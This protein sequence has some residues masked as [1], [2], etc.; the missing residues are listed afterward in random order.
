MAIS[1]DALGTSVLLNGGVALGVFFIFNFLRRQPFLADF[2]SAKRKLSIPFRF[3]PPRLPPTWFSWMEPV[4][5]MADEKF[6]VCAGFDA[7]AYCRFLKLAIRLS[8]LVSVVSCLITL[9]TNWAAGTFVEKQLKRQDQINEF[10][11]EKAMRE[12]LTEIPTVETECNTPEEPEDAVSNAAA[13]GIGRN[14][15]C[16]EVGFVVADFDK[17]SMTNIDENQSHLLWAHLISLY[18]ITFFTIRMLW[19]YW[20]ESLKWRILYLAWKRKG[21]S[22]HT[23]LVQDIAG[24]PHGT[25][26]GRIYDNIDGTIGRVLPQKFKEKVQQ[27]MQQGIGSVF[28]KVTGKVSG[29]MKDSVGSK[30]SLSGR[31]DIFE[32]RN[33]YVYRR[34]G[35]AAQ[36][37]K[38]LEDI[39]VNEFADPLGT[40]SF[41]SAESPR[42]TRSFGNSSFA[43]A[44]QY[45]TP[46]ANSV[47]AASSMS[48]VLPGADYMLDDSQGPL[49]AYPPEETLQRPTITGRRNLRNFRFHKAR[50]DFQTWEQAEAALQ[51]GV[52]VEELVRREF[53]RTYGEDQVQKVTVVKNELKLGGLYGAYATKKQAVEELTDKWISAL[54]RKATIKRKKVK[55]KPNKKDKARCDKWGVDKTTADEMEYKLWDMQDA[56]DKVRAEQRRVQHEETS[57][58]F[59]QLRSRQDQT[60]LA[61]GLLSYREDLWKASAAPDPAEIIWGSVSWRGWERSLRSMLVWGIFMGMLILM[62]PIIALIQ[63]IV[64]LEG[65]A[66]QDGTVGDI[67]QGI[68]DLP[69]VAQVLPGILPTLGLKIFLALVPIVLRLSALFIEGLPSFSAV[70][71]AVAK[72]FYIFQFI[73]VFVFVS[74]LG[75][76]SSGSSSGSGNAPVLT[77]AKDLADNP[78]QIADWI[79]TAVPQ[80]ASFYL[81]YILTNGLLAKGV[82]FLKIPGAA[83]FFLLSKLAGTK[84]Q[85]KK[86]WANQ[87]MQYGPE[88]ADHTITVLLL[89]LFGVQQPF[90][91][92]VSLAYFICNYFYAPDRK[93]VV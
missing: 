15:I 46:R 68:L 28:G 45:G 90:L 72:R 37:F 21:D 73:V 14:E 62:L 58:A 33:L 60:A 59:V 18:I 54:R 12:N 67:A 30:I 8:L 79:G 20:Q 40:G 64:N 87:Y 49:A 53:A 11:R 84:R 81:Q 16:K 38:R 76:A 44:S 32:D 23:I 83:I 92:L 51:N 74:I 69:V 35:D 24:T 5:T 85:K 88:L 36:P 27:A 93:S 61:T 89:F 3:R 31:N 91:P 63:Q 9:P 42:S 2:Y 13:N 48:G 19:A 34:P 50:T 86:T 78:Q 55:V 75:A 57:A 25:V 7:L 10:L 41:L 70:D 66:K 82:A 71:Y 47:R 43:L 22:A 39:G 17:T 77:L 80:Q 1:W 65:Y 52:S 6:V 26:I 4:F 56:L 29:K